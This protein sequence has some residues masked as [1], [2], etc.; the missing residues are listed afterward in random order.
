MLE[1]L[2]LPAV[3]LA[4]LAGAAFA[5]DNFTTWTDPGHRL[6]FR[7]PS[8]WQVTEMRSANDGAMRV[9]AGK[10]D[11]GCQIWL[12][13]RSQ[14]ASWAPIRVIQHYTA[15]LPAGTWTQ[16]FAGLPDLQGDLTASDIVVDSAGQW[17]TQH[18]TLRAGNAEATATLQG[19]PGFELIS[20][21]QSFD[22]QDRAAT[23]S[24]LGASIDIP[25]P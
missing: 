18:A 13:P 25:P 1:K 8:D 10:G 3:A 2:M 7:Y 12:L 4:A 19:R 22:G 23:F 6:M 24:R 11:F 21:C 16:T 17:P 20:L 14:T 5:Q 9:Y 15:P